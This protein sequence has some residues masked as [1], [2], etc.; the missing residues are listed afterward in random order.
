MMLLTMMELLGNG[1]G[2]VSRQL[3][4]KK[5]PQLLALQY[6]L[7]SYSE[8]CRASN[9]PSTRPVIPLLPFFQ[10]YDESPTAEK[11]NQTGNPPMGP[12][13]P[14]LSLTTAPVEPAQLTSTY[15]MLAPPSSSVI[16][17]P[18]PVWAR[19]LNGSL[20]G[21]D[22]HPLLQLSLQLFLHLLLPLS[23]IPHASFLHSWWPIHYP[24]LTIEVW[25]IVT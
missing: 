8:T 2:R 21:L 4:F 17:H 7:S 10:M 19:N 14:S 23:N 1:K 5:K 24:R 18:C 15:T 25:H 12:T 9:I 22:N 3:P 20:K 11:L 13:T 16:L 6:K